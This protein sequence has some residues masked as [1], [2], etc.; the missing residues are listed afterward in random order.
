MTEG[1]LKPNAKRA[2]LEAI[3]M[4]V[5]IDAPFQ[6]KSGEHIG[7]PENDVIRHDQPTRRRI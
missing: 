1:F 2:F 7:G 5:V 4:K 3:L 6:T